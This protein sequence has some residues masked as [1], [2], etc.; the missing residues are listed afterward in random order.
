MNYFQQLLSSAGIGGKIMFGAIVLVVLLGL[1]G[2]LKGLSRG[3]GRQAV[4]TLTV[5]LSAFLAFFITMQSANALYGTLGSMTV[6]EAVAAYSKMTIPETVSRYF[7]YVEMKTALSVISLPVAL[8]VL[9]VL[10]ALLFVLI[11]ALMLLL[12]ALIC[13]LLHLS[14]KHNNATTRLLGAVLGAVQGVAV[15][16]VV[17]VPVFGITGTYRDAV[18]ACRAQGD[19]AGAVIGAYDEYAAAVAESPLN[20]FTMRAGGDFL[21]GKLASMPAPGATVCTEDARVHAQNALRVTRLAQQ[22]AGTDFLSLSDSSKELIR[23]V[24]RTVGEDDYLASVVSGALRAAAAMY[25]GGEIPMELESPMKEL[26]DSAIGIFSDSDATNLQGDLDTLCAAYFLLSDNGALTALQDDSDAFARAMVKT[27]ENGQTV[28][29]RTA[30]ILNANP[31]TAPLVTELTKISVRMMA[32][33]MGTDSETATRVYEGVRTGVESILAIQ[34]ES[35]ET[36]AEYK[37][38]VAKSLDQT[39][40]ENN[41]ILH[42]EVIDTMADYVAEHYGE[43]EQMRQEDFNDILFSYYDA[44]AEYLQKHES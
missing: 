18:N 27:D 4:R 40:Q 38:A 29:K 39:F 22:L 8:V 5:A 41:I 14:K 6:E 19:D 25:A 11:S 3:I 24:I 42:E 10:F 34:K 15:A 23:N 32:N 30:A 17:L 37:Q 35:Y 26:A 43:V 2:A 1:V 28:I 31:R 16:L 20:A 33:Q 12:H 7:P 9:P 13:W 21:Y 44:Y 36:E